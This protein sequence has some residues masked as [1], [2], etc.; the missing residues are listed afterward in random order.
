MTRVLTWTSV[1]GL[2][3]QTGSDPETTQEMTRKPLAQRL[4]STRNITD[5]TGRGADI[6]R[7]RPDQPAGPLLLQD[8]RCPACRTGAGEHGREHVRGHL[9]EVQYDRRPELHVGLEHTVRAPGAQLGEGG[10][11]QGEGHLVAWR[12]QFLGS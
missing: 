12:V 11:L 10:V 7:G 9:G 1:P 8:V 6:A 2:A 3:A 4:V 5:G